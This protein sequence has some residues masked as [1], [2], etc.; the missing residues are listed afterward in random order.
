MRP[1][2]T[3][4]IPVY[5][6]GEMWKECWESLLPS[7]PLF[8]E[9]FVSFNKSQNQAENE[10]LIASSG[11]SN[12]RIINRTQLYS[13]VGH[14]IEMIKD[15]RTDYAIWL[16]DDDLL[17]TQGVKELVGI[18]AQS[19]TPTSVFGSFEWMDSGSGRNVISRELSAFPE[20]ISNEAFVLSDIDKY[21][22]F[23]LSGLCFPSKLAKNFLPAFNAF[24]QG[25]KVDGMVLTL[26]GTEKI[27][28][29][30]H[31][32][33][34]VRIHSGQGGLTAPISVKVR[35]HLTYY[36]TQ[37]LYAPTNAGSRRLTE[38]LLNL[39]PWRPYGVTH[40]LKLAL[41]SVRWPRGKRFGAFLYWTA[42]WFFTQFPGQFRFRLGAFRRRLFA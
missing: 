21:F 7:A 14:L 34:K 29:T 17:E 15:L 3:L 41:Q 42:Y 32:L 19:K 1:T 16:C 30:N 39:T 33:V 8:D 25:V 9:I 22:A 20:G 37:A 24:I 36:F 23:T 35:D 40:M 2:L 31:P 38:Y 26:P 5:R 11:L 27:R 12:L 6:G 13:P 18:L 4:A 10:H 28:Q